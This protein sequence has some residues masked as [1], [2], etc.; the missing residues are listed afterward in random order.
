MASSPHY[1]VPGSGTGPGQGTYGGGFTP[2]GGVM[3]NYYDADN[4]S[5]GFVMDRRLA[6]LPR[7]MPRARGPAHSKVPTLLESMPLE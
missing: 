7:S 6:H 1:D 2:D 5:H 3:G 4:L